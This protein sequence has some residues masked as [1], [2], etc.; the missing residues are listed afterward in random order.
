[1]TDSSTRTETQLGESF[2]A[3]PVSI[4]SLVSLLV[5]IALFGLGTPV[6]KWLVENG[7]HFGTVKK[8]AISY[9]NVLFVG[10]LCSAAIVFLYFRP[11]RAA[12]QFVE[13]LR[14]RTFP[15]LANVLFANVLAPTFVILALEDTSAMTVILLLQADATFHALAGRFLLGEVIS[16]R[17]ALGFG[18][19]ACGII[20]LGLVASHGELTTGYVY[21]LLAALFRA[22]GAITARKTLA[23]RRL[24]PAFLIARNLLGAL[25]FYVL[26]MQMFG[27]GHFKD[28]F[29]VGLW[30]LMVVYA[31]LVIVVG[32]FSWYRALTDLPSRTVSAGWTLE[33]VF[34]L[35][36][37]YF[38]LGE[39]PASLQWISVGLI[40]TGLAIANLGG[41]DRKQH[42]DRADG[43]KIYRPVIS[44]DRPNSGV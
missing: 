30:E 9:C 38:L 5:A 7:G 33:P 24:L 6:L 43:K 27:P 16:R 11:D 8:D 4:F 32:Q 36:F 15:L 17:A 25:V 3:A 42:S 31:A 35:L 34:G 20:V 13:I 44:P 1:M 14:T 39:A 12:K 41:K 37:A 28:A 19:I 23:D 40:F 22:L 2:P 10:N 18:L 21:T 26:A 29:S